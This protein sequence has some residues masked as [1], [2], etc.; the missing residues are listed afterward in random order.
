MLALGALVPPPTAWAQAVL[1]DGFQETVAL[2]GLEEPTAVRFAVDGRVFVAEKSG[3]VKLFDDLA[4]QTP[5]IFADLRTN[6]F[7]ADDRGLLALALHPGFPGVPYVY[8]LYTLDAE[9]GGTPPRWG[10]AGTTS[11]SCPTPPGSGTDG[12]VVGGRL[13]RLEASGDV[14]S[15]SEEVLLEN[16]CQQ[17][18]SHSIG[19]LAFGP[20][21]ALYVSA[22]EGASFTIVDYGQRGFPAVNPCGDPPSGVGGPQDPPTAEGGALRAQDLQTEGDPVTYDGALLR[23]DPLT[24]NALPDNPLAGGVTLDDDR[25]I[26]YGL[27]NP[28]RIAARPGTSE[29]WMGDVGWGRWEEIDRI[30]DA[31]DAIVENFG[32][33]CYEGNLPQPGYDATNLAV[34]E[35]LY[36]TPGSVTSAQHVYRH[37]DRVVA[38]DSCEPGSSA[39]SG[40]AFYAGG[41]Y[42]DVFDGALVFADYSRGC[43][44]AML[45]DGSGDPDAGS[46]STLASGAAGPVDLQVGPQGDLFYVDIFGG[47]V[48]RIS[49]VGGTN[50]PPL[51]VIHA[52]TSDGPVPLSVQ[53]DASASSDPNP[54]DTLTYSWDLDG[55]EVFGDATSIAPSFTYVAP[56]KTTVRLRVTDQGGLS[57]TSAIVITAGNTAPTATIDFP[58]AGTTWNVGD[59]ITFSGSATDTE[60][61]VLPPSALSW[62]LILH[63]CPSNCHRHPVES[64]RNVA[65]G[66]FVTFDHEHPSFLEL[67]LTAT[68]AGGLQDTV[69][70]FLH[71]NAV[72]LTFESV[73]AGLT[74]AFDAESEATPFS[75]TVIVGSTHSVSAPA[76]QTLNQ[77]SYGFVSWSDGGAGSHLVTAPAV[78]GTY[79]ASFAAQCDDCDDGNPCTTDVCDPL[80][81]CTHPAVDDGTPCS[82]ASI[83]NGDETCQGGTCSSGAPLVCDD[84]D[85]CTADAC[86]EQVAGGCV[87][88][89]GGVDLDAPTVVLGKLD[90]PSSTLGVRAEIALA[91]SAG[92]VDPLGDG[93]ALQLQDRAGALVQRFDLPAGGQ[94][95]L[96]RVGWTVN[97]AGTRWRYRDPAGAIGGIYSATLQLVDKGRRLRIAVKG[98]GAYEIARGDEPITL[99]ILASASP[100]ECGQ[101]HFAAPT[102]ARPSCRFNNR[103][104]VLQC[105]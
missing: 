87:H 30:G 57:T 39:I 76:P 31:T 11:D 40:L 65:G 89:Y 81:A 73:P 29:I 94:D 46:I 63:H 51:A 56:E 38:G 64:F 66:S 72:A 22:G 25:V 88:A 78:A 42:P 13:S 96:T 55:D 80:V 61:L 95:P 71:P 98:H 32:W 16:W 84:G 97:K 68:D 14:A 20:D 102:G 47:T 4:D 104:S 44:W 100:L 92:V 19:D 7:N 53:F 62:S 79:S 82:D 54:G 35:A 83:C 23:V 86:D 60:Q 90:R 49:Y 75:R 37:S 58:A 21:G 99:Q 48:R 70:V 15:G 45:V 36:Q 41:T 77:I 6:V 105:R 91:S 3:I 74:L 17:F 93:L 52:D 18:P 67:Q 5:S 12:C 34:C 10:S 50:D 8:V 101:V 9:I 69:S 2:S 26:A 59:T 24:G 28:F 33:P 27:R 85:L 103:G 43:I 1:P